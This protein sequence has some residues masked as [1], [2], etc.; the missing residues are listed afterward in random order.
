[1]ANST[2][3]YPRGVLSELH[4]KFE[5]TRSIVASTFCAPMKYVLWYVPSYLHIMHF[6][7]SVVV[8]LTMNIGL[9]KQ[10]TMNDYQ[11]LN[12]PTQL[13]TYRSHMAKFMSFLHGVEY[14]IE[15]EYT[16]EQLR[17][18]HPNDI[19]RWMCLLAYGREQPGPED[20]PIYRRAE[21]L[22]YYSKSLSY[23]FHTQ[24]EWDDDTRR[25]NPTLSAAV[26]TLI[27]AVEQEEVRKQGS[28]SKARRDLQ[29][30]EFVQVISFLQQ[31]PDFKRQLVYPTMAKF[32][33]NMIARLDDTAGLKIENISP[34]SRF[35]FA[36][37]CQLCW[38]KNV[39]EERRAPHQIL[40]GSG[41]SRYCIL[42]GLG[43][44]LEL[45]IE[46]G[47]GLLAT[48]VFVEPGDTP[49]R[50][51]TACYNAI[52]TY[53]FD[54]PHFVR[55]NGVPGLLGTH[56]LRKLPTTHAANCSCSQEEVNTRGRWRTDGKKVISRYISTILPFPDAKV[57]SRLCIGG[58]VKY[59]LKE[60]SNVSNQW[61]LDNVVPGLVRRFPNHAVPLT[62]ALPILWA[63]FASPE[64][65]SIPIP[66]HKRN[67]I[68]SAYALLNSTLPPEDSNPVEK[69]QLIISNTDG[70]LEI[71]EAGAYAAEGGGAV[72]Q[73]NVLIQHEL[74]SI[75]THMRE[76]DRDR[77]E[78]KLAQRQTLA[79]VQ[80]IQPLVRQMGRAITIL[81]RMTAAPGGYMLPVAPAYQQQAGGGGVAAAGAGG[82]AAAAPA[83]QQADEDSVVSGAAH[84]A[85]IPYAST[86]SPLP[87][88][89]Y[90]LWQEYQVGI[91][92]RK[93]AK[94]FSRRERGAVKHQYARRKVVWDQISELIRAGETW[95][96]AIDRIYAVYGQ[97]TSVTKIINQLR[98]DRRNGG[99]AALRL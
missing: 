80:H 91:A 93:P 20:H 81:Q 36:V 63:C 33:Y 9:K 82:E 27:N 98:I 30:S 90:V 70:C 75:H 8:I 25:G 83:L 24:R 54:N 99:P 52:K 50:V 1:M 94:N 92:G 35:P 95:Q 32:Q 73:Q 3:F 58:P 60:G 4:R 38:S 16:L 42:L 18:V 22:K 28:P 57:A 39:R 66:E 14:P 65:C 96:V 47:D 15:Q 53:V 62:F 23:F 2:F 5:P 68:R 13:R 71:T 6:S 61:L 86:L 59:V 85:A 84:A 29:H 11:Q 56:S 78:M 72:N 34:N 40:L 64:E 41:D 48:H 76:Q 87:S 37:N 31:Y 79:A 44:Y 77:A 74:R 45:F 26:N 89:L 49:K 17:D 51:K 12:P 88:S 43:L 19:R 97:R 69:V 10:S 7:V 67:G 21:T 55:A 46:R